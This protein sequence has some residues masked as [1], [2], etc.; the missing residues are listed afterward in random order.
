MITLP[1][2][3][4]EKYAVLGLGKSGLATAAALGASGA[5]VVVWDDNQASRDEAEK[6]GYALGNPA[7]INLYGFKALVL[8]PGI[9]LTHPAPHPAV[10]RCKTAKVPVIGDIELLFRACPKATFVG[11]TGTNG[12]S[13]TTALIAHILKSAGRP[14]QVGGNLGT[15]VLALEPLELIYLVTNEYDGTDELGFAWDDP[16]AT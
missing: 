12:K 16:L 1:N 10:L 3:T 5:N 15:P 4:G 14:M 13:T 11:V 8:A 7:E 6:A 9:P 2:I